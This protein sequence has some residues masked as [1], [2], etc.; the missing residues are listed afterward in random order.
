MNFDALTRTERHASALAP[1]PGLLARLRRRRRIPHRQSARF[2]SADPGRIERRLAESD[3]F[4]RD[5]PVGKLYHRKQASFRE[6]SPTDSL[7]VTVGEDGL[8][9]SHVD[10]HSPLA[11][12]QPGGACRYSLLRVAAHN[13]SGMAGD[14]VRLVVG[15]RPPRAA[16]PEAGTGPTDDESVVET[17]ASRERRAASPGSPEVAVVA[18]LGRTYAV[19]DL[20]CEH[21][22]QAIEAGLRRRAGVEWVEVDVAARTVLVTGAITEEAARAAIDQAGHQV[23]GVG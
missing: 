14:L 9:T 5:T 20:G 15:P 8:V 4:C 11:R 18:T 21:C 16:D 2:A 3:C 10:R 1:G 7:H 19:P 23:A 12:R 13:V 6:I 17:V 22:K